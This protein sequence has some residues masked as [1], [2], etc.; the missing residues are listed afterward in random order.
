MKIDEVCDKNQC[1]VQFGP[2]RGFGTGAVDPKLAD[3]ADANQD[4]KDNEMWKQ[5]DIEDEKFY[6]MKGHT[7]RNAR[8]LKA[9]QVARPKQRIR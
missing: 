6:R 8:H 3:A 9:K 7:E 2:K 4:A 5:A 1:V